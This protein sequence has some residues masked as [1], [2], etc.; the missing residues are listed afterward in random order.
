VTILIRDVWNS[1]ANSS[2]HRGG[3]YGRAR[4][5]R[6]QPALANGAPRRSR[7][8]CSTWVS[9]EEQV[10]L[11]SF[12]EEPPR[13]A[14]S[15]AKPGRPT[16]AR[17][18]SWNNYRFYEYGFVGRLAGRPLQTRNGCYRHFSN[19]I[20]ISHSLPMVVSL[21]RRSDYCREECECCAEEKG[22]GEN[23]FHQNL[24]VCNRPCKNDARMFFDK[25][26]LSLPGF[27]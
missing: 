2:G 7:N 22:K 14:A 20:R 5:G 17:I 19:T 25:I 12:G 23:A 13:S 26:L 24:L 1:A 27:I 6:I 15:T 11:L 18:W 8:T 9:R 10:K 4:N 3:P 21:D 16:A